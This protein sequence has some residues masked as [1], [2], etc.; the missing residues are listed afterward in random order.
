MLV[1]LR[2]QPDDLAYALAEASDGDEVI[3]LVKELDVLQADATF[4]ENL[5]KELFISLSNDVEKKDLLS[6]LD[7]LR[8]IATAP[9]I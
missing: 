9:L 2:V 1:A 7:E 4:T 5:I 3:A 6:F 8:A